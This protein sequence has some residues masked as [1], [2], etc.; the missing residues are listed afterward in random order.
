MTPH[1]I[2]VD[3]GSAAI[4]WP[5]SAD[6][7]V[8]GPTK[9]VGNLIS[10]GDQSAKGTTPLYPAIGWTYGQGIHVSR[11]FTTAPVPLIFNESSSPFD[12]LNL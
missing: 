5:H 9:I 7:K 1:V 3:K 2:D 10:R 6:R 4:Q 12:D 11:A 8:V